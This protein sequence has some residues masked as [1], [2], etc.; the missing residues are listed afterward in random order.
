M[1]LTKNL[2][3]K[4]RQFCIVTLSCLLAACGGGGG[5]GSDSTST[6]PVLPS[7]I[8]TI[9]AKK[10]PIVTGVATN[11][12]ITA[13]FNQSMLA[14][15]INAS[16]VKLS[17]PTGTPIV[18][19][20]TYDSVNRTAILKPTINLPVS[21]ICEATITTAATNT[22]GLA[23][24]KNYVWTFTTS[25]GQNSASATVTATSPIGGATGVCLSSNVIVTFS[26]PMDSS[27]INTTT[28]TVTNPAN[29]VMPGVVTY[30]LLSNTANFAVTN[31]TGYVANTVY[32]ANIT[33]GA[34]SLDGNPS[35]PYSVSFTT[36]TAACGAPIVNLASIST[37]GSFGGGAGATNQGLNTFID[38][39]LG[40]TGVCTMITGFH[41]ANNSY[42]ETPLIS[43]EVTGQVF[44]APP[45]P[46]TEEQLAIA[47][48]AA[49]DA[50]SAYNAL[51]AI[52]PSTTKYDELGGLTLTPGTYSSNST[53]HITNGNLTL[54]AGGDANA[55][56]VFQAPSSLTVGL[57]AV[58]YAANPFQ[59]ILIN[60][61]QA[62]NIFWQVYSQARIEDGS[63]MIGTIIAQAGVTI[64]T[65]GQAVQTTLIGRAIGLNAST[66]MVNTT[67]IIP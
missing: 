4:P 57:A 40:T 21:T 36:G 6:K 25:T 48:L 31:P 8:L 42:T 33:A 16:S 7:V 59:V 24:V 34:K 65:A 26:K 54:D 53:L 51:V 47:T 37:Y 58:S 29:A 20:V 35:S 62:K 23:L 19:T 63:T 56:W 66:T 3:I 14:S 1:S 52:M 49:K 45:A 2:I 13:K 5:G 67:V 60:G 10:A 11:S 12:A 64:S 50:V 55:T 41:D 27:T 44:C 22:A 30:D 39:D 15:S 32:T 38:G 17:C 18:G 43:G 28:F 46:G 61:A 9:P